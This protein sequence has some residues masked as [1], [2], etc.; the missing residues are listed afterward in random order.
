MN[1]TVYI[2]VKFLTEL[3]LVTALYVLPYER[4]AHFGRKL[5]ICLAGCY[6]FSFFTSPLILRYHLLGG[7]AYTILDI[8]RYTAIFSL[9][10]FT[11]HSL[12]CFSIRASFFVCAG[13]YAIQHLVI[14]VYGFVENRVIDRIPFPA[15]VLLYAG[16]L[17]ACYGAAYYFVIR[18]LQ[19]QDAARLKANDTFL[20]NILAVVSLIILSRFTRGVTFGSLLG[21]FGFMA[22][23]AVCSVFLLVLQVK[24]YRQGE[25]ERENEQIEYVL[26]QERKR[27]ESFRDSVD[28]LNIKCHDLKH[29]IH[30]L[31]QHGG[32]MPS[33]EIKELENGIGQYE[34]YSDTGVPALDI[35][36]GVKYLT[37][38]ANGIEF[39][40]V[41]EGKLL[42]RL[43]EADIY[44]LFGNALD[45]AIE[46]EVKLPE[47][48]R[49]IRL[50]VRD[51]GNMLFIRVENAYGGPQV[52]EDGLE[53]SKQDRRY[54]GFGVKSMRHIAEK[55]SGEMDVNTAGGV[56]AV[57]FLFTF[58]L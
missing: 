40:A 33:E 50:S 15:L 37:C 14:K 32:M 19:Q 34:S 42:A 36:L 2:A 46:Y 26:E 30:R 21:E 22:Y 12:F 11:V 16:F 51:R 18:Q 5:V 28:Y 7:A 13:S 55:Y 57:S 53:S 41:V 29:Q 47:G 3:L 8:A 25:M 54:H 43:S 58:D 31:K 44:S 39:T 56:F 10:A 23:G 38:K 45:N 35:I 48:E 27:F 6:A 49:L 20:L 4:R 52:T 1:H 9:V 24:I 17:A